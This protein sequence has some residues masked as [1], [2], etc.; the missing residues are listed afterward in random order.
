VVATELIFLSKREDAPTGGG[1]FS[2]HEDFSDLDADIAD[3]KF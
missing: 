2:N 3:D 1:T